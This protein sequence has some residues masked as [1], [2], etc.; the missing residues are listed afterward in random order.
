MKNRFVSASG[1]WLYIF[2]FPQ[3][4]KKSPGCCEYFNP[5]LKRRKLPQ[6]PGEVRRW[7]MGYPAGLTRICA[8]ATILSKSFEKASCTVLDEFPAPSSSSTTPPLRSRSARRKA[9]GG[10]DR[11]GGAQGGARS[12]RSQSSPSKFS[13]SKSVQAPDY[14][15]VAVFVAGPLLCSSKFDT[16]T[17]PTPREQD[18]VD[19]A[20]HDTTCLHVHWLCPLAVRMP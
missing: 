13:A 15:E 11:E 6:L 18:R 2:T 1:G 5:C 17:P 14:D 3:Q 10:E 16:A 9:Q 7:T 12:P 8:L 19:R 4:L 20:D